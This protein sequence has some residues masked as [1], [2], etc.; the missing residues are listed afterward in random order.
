VRNGKVLHV[1][2]VERNILHTVEWRRANWICHILRGICLLKHC[3][4]GKIEGRIEVTER[5]EKICKQ[6]LD[7]LQDTVN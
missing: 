1:V 4:E 5:R 7:S 3:I 2:K 6:L